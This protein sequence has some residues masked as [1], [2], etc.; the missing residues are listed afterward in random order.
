MRL[1]LAF[2]GVEWL[3]LTVNADGTCEPKREPAKDRLRVEAVYHLAP[4]TY[5]VCNFDKAYVCFVQFKREGRQ[6]FGR[7][8]YPECVRWQYTRAHKESL[9][10]H[11]RAACKWHVRLRRRVEAHKAFVSAFVS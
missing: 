5:S 3:R 8:D 11:I 2:L 10:K 9:C 7:C 6:K 1:A 4:D